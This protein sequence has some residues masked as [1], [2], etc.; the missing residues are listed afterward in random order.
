MHNLVIAFFQLAVNIYILDIEHSQ[1]LKDLIL[2][3]ISKH[4]LASLIQ[5]RRLVLILHLLLQLVHGFLPLEVVG[6]DKKEG[7]LD[8]LKT[9]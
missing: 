2:G 7:D 5:L 1:I 6:T 3:P 9:I 8:M 4:W